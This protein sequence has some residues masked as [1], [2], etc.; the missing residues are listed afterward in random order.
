MN[1]PTNKN[2]SIGREI[3]PSDI[4]I[5]VVEDE[6]MMRSLLSDAL[7]DIG[8]NV[9]IASNG[10]EALEKIQ[11]AS[12]EIVLTG[13]RLPGMS[14]IEVI[15]KFKQVKSDICIIVITAYPSVETAVQAMREGAY[16]YVTK[17]L[18]LDELRIIIR[19]AAEKQVLQRAKDVYEELSI[20]D[21]LTNI[22]NHRYF[23]EVLPREI[24]RASR[25]SRPLSLIMIDIDDFKIFND[26]N[27]HVAG[28]N[29]LK[30]LSRVLVKSVREVDLVFRYG[31]E[32]F[33]ILLPETEKNGSPAVARRLRSQIEQRSF[34][35]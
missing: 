20:T 4:N 29:L 28:D 7:S 19:R 8:Y 30:Q 34:L 6:E 21:G 27:G 25:Y 3:T 16:D 13:L 9:Q 33:A 12:F 22:F 1:T 2:D 18:N 23:Q 31:G 14:G 17:P 15:K 5:L 24:H 35:S 11:Q 26:H 32:E 10:E